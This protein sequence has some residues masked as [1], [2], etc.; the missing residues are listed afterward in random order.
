MGVKLNSD[1]GS[2]HRECCEELNSVVKE[3]GTASV[4]CGPLLWSHTYLDVTGGSCNLSDRTR[5]K[6]GG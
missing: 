3:A 6:K 4:L 2:I 1:V 5:N